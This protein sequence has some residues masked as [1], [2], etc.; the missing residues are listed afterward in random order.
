MSGVGGCVRPYPGRLGKQV[1]GFV[2]QQGYSIKPSMIVPAGTPDSRAAK[3]IHRT[4]LDLLVLPF[5]LHRGANGEVLDAVGILLELPEEFEQLQMSIFMP[6]R[7]FSWGASFQRRLDTLREYRPMLAASMLVAHQDELGTATLAAR[8]R[9]AIEAA[10][11]A[12]RNQRLSVPAG[13]APASTR[14]SASG[15]LP[16]MPVHR[17]SPSSFPPSAA[18]LN[19]EDVLPPSL[20]GEVDS[21]P[22]SLRAPVSGVQ[23]PVSGVQGPSSGIVSREGAQSAPESA[24]ESFRRAA[25]IGARARQEAGLSV[26]PARKKSG[27]G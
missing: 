8:M 25:E 3:W 14:F 13:G 27:D 12:A 24:R 2:E 11:S 5:H 17:P 9:R 10:R 26:H 21:G 23:G 20:S 1:T 18:W 15:A 16:L 22:G 7:A 4:P 19:G 6:V